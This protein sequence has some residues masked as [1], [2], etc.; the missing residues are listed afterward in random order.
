MDIF[1]GSGK[2]GSDTEHGSPRSSVAPDD[3][4][5]PP[6]AKVARTGRQY[7]CPHCSYSADK[8]VSLNRH[9]R[10]HTPSVTPVSPAPTGP[11]DSET[12]DES[13][14]AGGQLPPPALDRYCANCDIRFSSVKTFRAHKTHYCDT[15]HVV[16]P[17]PAVSPAAASQVRNN[18][19]LFFL[20]IFW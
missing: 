9:M 7:T 14:A 8:K 10:M 4:S 1:I 6:P 12:A 18:F 13:A 2:E 19:K 11:S 3:D 16:K 15:R 20:A 5:A 17:N